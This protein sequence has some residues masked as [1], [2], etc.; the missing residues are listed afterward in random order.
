MHLLFGWVLKKIVWNEMK[1]IQTSNQLW[2]WE[3]FSQTY[4]KSNVKQG[5]AKKKTNRKIKKKEEERKKEKK[6]RLSGI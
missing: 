6:S 1:K 4:C 2:S 5:G 3:I